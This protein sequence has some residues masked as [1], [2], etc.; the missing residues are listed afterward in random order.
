MEP[1]VLIAFGFIL[2]VGGYSLFR[3]QRKVRES[4]LRD[5]LSEA[6]GEL[7]TARASVT[8]QVR[9]LE[10]RLHE[11]ARD[12]EAQL[13][14][15]AALLDQLIADADARI[16]TL[17]QDLADEREMRLHSADRSSVGDQSVARRRAA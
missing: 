4:Q 16:E 17:K 9:Q 12:L 5:T 3:S 13:A 14:T 8:G 2:V 15:R 11:H 7:Q 6:N 1:V 10:V